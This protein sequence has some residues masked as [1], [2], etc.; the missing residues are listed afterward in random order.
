M[1]LFETIS[2]HLVNYEDSPT[3]VL[4]FSWDLLIKG[5]SYLLNTSLSEGR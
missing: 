5:K 4:V 1:V 2:H 3:V